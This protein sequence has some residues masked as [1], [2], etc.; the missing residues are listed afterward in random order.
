MTSADDPYLRIEIPLGEIRI[1][2]G[3]EDPDTV[4]NI[5]GLVDLSDGT[6]RT[7]TALTLAEVDRLMKK[8]ERSGESSWGHTFG[9]RTW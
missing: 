1:L 2:L 9:C 4:E 7:F 6:T 5:E 3:G 8:W